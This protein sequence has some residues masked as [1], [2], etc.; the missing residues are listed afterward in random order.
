MQLI[1]NKLVP[2]EGMHIV[3]IS[4]NEAF[5]A[6]IYIPPRLQISD[7]TEITEQEYQSKY[8]EIRDV[9]RERMASL[10]AENAKLKT[11]VDQLQ[12]NKTAT[13]EQLTAVQ[14]ALCDI[15]EQII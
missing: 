1:N 13:D 15:Y 11:T 6:E 12:A 8:C 10:E 3:R 14:M 7:F 2:S 5:E 4:T 9:F